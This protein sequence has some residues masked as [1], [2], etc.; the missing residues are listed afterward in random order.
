MYS[1]L[2]LQVG[3]ADTHV[4][5]ALASAMVDQGDTEHETGAALS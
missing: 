3:Y 4:S 2:G 1:L 5:T